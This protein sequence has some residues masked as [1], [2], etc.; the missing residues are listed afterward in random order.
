MS[1]AAVRADI[2]HVSWCP[3]DFP[4][5]LTMKHPGAWGGHTE[6]GGGG[7]RGQTDSF[8]HERKTSQPILLNRQT[9]SSG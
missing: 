3:P 7:L 8:K 1:R 5:N 4:N 6:R 9:F 2:L